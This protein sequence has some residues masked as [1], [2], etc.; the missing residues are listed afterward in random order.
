M[1]G[2][3]LSAVSCKVTETE[4]PTEQAKIALPM[5]NNKRG[6]VQD[7]ADP[8]VLV[9]DGVYYLYC[10]SDANSDIG[11][12]VYRS[13]NL[14]NWERPRAVNNG[15]ALLN[16]DVWGDRWFW[17]GDVVERDGKFYMYYTANEH[18]SVAVSA[19]PIGPFTQ[20]SEQPMHETVK[21]IDAGVFID[22]DG[23]A[24][25]YFVRFDNGNV[26]YVAE[27]ADDL[28]T[29]KEQTIQECFRAGQPW[30][31]GKHVPVASV[32]EGAFMMKHNGLYYLTYTA[33]HFASIDYAVGYAIS[34]G[35]TGPWEKYK[36]NPI[37]AASDQVFGPGNGVFVPSPDGSELFFIYHTHFN[38]KS[39]TPRQLAIDRA[40]F[41]VNSD[42]GPD[43]IVI[44]GPT[45]TEQP[46]PK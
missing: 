21:E 4:L 44:A 2:M 33:N 45:V 26:L 20:E 39:A 7:C 16:Q 27:L 6:I 32:N 37:L 17:A 40:R 12:K 23:K 1:V 38:S 8:S 18:L 24:Y 46:M 30:E 9:Y 35:P 43:I 28:L 19:S 36:N 10:T 29:M 42:G 25:I 3:L 5:Y 15:Y 34:A 31:F 41:A 13:T 14:V 22:D 11:I